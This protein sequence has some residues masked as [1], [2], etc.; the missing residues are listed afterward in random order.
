MIL[1]S[2]SLSVMFLGTDTDHSF[3]M[4]SLQ[5]VELSMHSNFVEIH[6]IT[7]FQLG[8]L[9]LNVMQSLIQAPPV[10]G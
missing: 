8:D 1:D 6:V 9:T 3:V 10:V 2:T 4:L 7:D 5:N